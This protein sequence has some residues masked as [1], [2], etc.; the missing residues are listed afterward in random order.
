MA[1][2]NKVRGAKPSLLTNVKQGN[3]TG[4]GMGEILGQS[5]TS[6]RYST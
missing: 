5:P 4:S 3:E 6:L 1:A 2:P